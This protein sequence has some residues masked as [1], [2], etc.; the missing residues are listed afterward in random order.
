MAAQLTSINGPPDLK[1][2]ECI[3]LATNSLPDPFGP[4]IN[5]FALVG[6]IFSIKLLTLLICFDSPIISYLELVFLVFFGIFFVFV[7][8]K[9]LLT[10][11]SKLF[12][13]GGFS[14]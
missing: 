7:L 6:A 2:L 8:T 13:S 10:E 11:F 5:T 14:I 1:L 3:C 4:N 12:K 9:A